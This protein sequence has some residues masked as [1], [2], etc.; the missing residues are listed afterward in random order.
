MRTHDLSA[1]M[2]QSFATT[3]AQINAL[4]TLV[5]ARRAEG[6]HAAV[7]QLEAQVTALVQQLVRRRNAWTTLQGWDA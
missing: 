3:E 5:A 7:A 1:T 6:D 4:E 2:H